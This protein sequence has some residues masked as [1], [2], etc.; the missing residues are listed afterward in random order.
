MAPGP[1]IRDVI[2]AVLFAALLV[3]TMWFATAVLLV[4]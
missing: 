4:I 2:K 1:V 3:P